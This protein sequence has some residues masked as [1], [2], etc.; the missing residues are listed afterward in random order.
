MLQK[1]T[2][3]LTLDNS[4]VHSLKCIHVNSNKKYGFVGDL[5]SVVIKKFKIKKKLFKKQIYFGLII[6]SKINTYRLDGM[7][8]KSDF[9]RILVLN[10]ESNSFLGTRLYGPIYKEIRQDVYGKKRLLKYE[11]IVSLSKKII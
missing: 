3:I 4:G 8:I 5:L 10:K 11:K 1:E 7:F 6:C 9:N 2:K